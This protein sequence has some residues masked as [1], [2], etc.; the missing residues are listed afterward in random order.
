MG[1]LASGTELSHDL[2]PGRHAWV[3]VARGRV[4]VSDQELGPGD[5]AAI[6]EESKIAL[7]ALE[8]ADVV[9]FDLG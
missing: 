7:R 3:Q 1:S 4:R 9:L 2:E 5:G 6:S 8:P